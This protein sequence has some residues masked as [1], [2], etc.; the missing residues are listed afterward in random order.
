MRRRAMLPDLGP[1]TTGAGLTLYSVDR[2]GWSGVFG[3]VMGAAQPA[4]VERPRIVVVMRLA[5]PAAVAQP[6][7][8]LAAAEGV[9]HIVVGAALLRVA[10]DPGSRMDAVL[11]LVSGTAEPR[12]LGDRG[13]GRRHGETM[14]GGGEGVKVAPKTRKTLNSRRS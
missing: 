9:P 14:R 6:A 12:G 1:T 8:H 11:E 10:S 4:H 7:L 2:A 5:D 3:G 13:D